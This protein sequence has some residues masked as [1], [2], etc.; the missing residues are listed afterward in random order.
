M[1]A[2]TNM[3]N[4]VTRHQSRAAQLAETLRGLQSL[5]SRG[6]RTMRAV[7]AKAL[8]RC[9]IVRIV[10]IRGLVATVEI[11]ATSAELFLS[12]F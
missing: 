6:N 10:E 1:S 8:A 4:L 2:L 11:N 3:S 5:Q 7:D 12:N 9:A